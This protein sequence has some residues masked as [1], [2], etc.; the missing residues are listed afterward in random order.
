MEL[1]RKGM[2]TRLTYVINL[3][4]FN[5][6]LFEDGEDRCKAR[7]KNSYELTEFSKDEIYI[8]RRHDARR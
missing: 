7:L 3:G 2:A 5:D 6:T 1:M 8:A 4:V